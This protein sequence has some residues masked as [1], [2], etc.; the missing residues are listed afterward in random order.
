MHLEEL[1]RQNRDTKEEV[2]RL[3]LAAF[4]LYTGITFVRLHFFVNG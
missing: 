1:M 2:E 4:Q 3:N